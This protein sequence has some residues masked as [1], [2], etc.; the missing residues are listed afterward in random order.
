MSRSFVVI[1]GLALV[2]GG[3]T[4]QEST[5][6][7]LLLVPE[8]GVDDATSDAA[9]DASVPLPDQTSPT[10]GSAPDQAVP[11]FFGKITNGSRLHARYVTTPEG[12]IDFR[13]WYDTDRQENCDFSRASDGKWRCLPP[14]TAIRYST[15]LKYVDAA[16]TKPSML[17]A[18]SC[19]ISPSYVRVR[20]GATA[21]SPQELRMM[22]SAPS[23]GSNAYS[24]S[25]SG[26]CV[27]AALPANPSSYRLLLPVDETKY[28]A[29]VE[30]LNSG[31]TRLQPHMLQ[32]ADG[33]IQQYSSSGSG[34]TEYKLTYHDTTT[35]TDCTLT[36][37]ESNSV[38]R[39]LPA[40]AA[41]VSQTT[42]SDAACTKPAGISVSCLPTAQ[43]ALKTTSVSG[44]QSGSTNELYAVGAKSAT[45]YS[46]ATNGS[47]NPSSA[48]ESVFYPIGNTINIASWAE[49][50]VEPRGPGRLWPRRW[51]ASGKIQAC[52]SAALASGDV[53]Y[54]LSKTAPPALFS[55]GQESM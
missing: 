31:S 36:H 3:C 54:S 28:L 18:P 46:L 42:F 41:G 6:P 16:C 52:V 8:A 27:P 39:C 13:G 22:G 4:S 33:S 53:L 14:V 29:A 2:C 12:F 9:G 23:F 21:C 49:F 19:A 30:V 32:G 34:G 26:Q 35:S 15:L 7:D 44:C 20:Y 17:D 5:D 1:M 37:G 10:D 55:A 24:M 40:T 38:Y 45:G 50:V 25:S 11:K 48:S 47:C 51:T 43:Y